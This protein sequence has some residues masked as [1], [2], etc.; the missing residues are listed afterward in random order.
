M[1]PAQQLGFDMIRQYAAMV[2][3]QPAARWPGVNLRELWA[4]RELF[5]FLVW[6]DMKVRYAQTVL[7]AGWAIVQPLATMV[8]FTI[9]FG[10]LA[11]LPSDGVPYAVFSLAALTPWNYFAGALVAASNSVLSHTDVITKIYFPRLIVPTAS[12]LGG[13]PNLAITLVILLI[14]LFAYGIT[15]APS[16]ILVIPLLL[17]IMMMTASGV[18]C[19][20]GAL[21]VQYR[22]VRNVAGVLVQLWMY[23]SPIVYPLSL[24]PDGYRALYML[25]PMVGVIEGFRSVLLG[26]VPLPY[27]AIAM[28]LVASL[29]LFTTGLICFRRMEQTFA[30]VA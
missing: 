26:T 6:R 15:P 2:D 8:V 7:G 4:Y 18:G 12:V 20:L 9:I 21:A 23:A 30:D 5:V 14:V 25:N 27:A 19:W 13:L 3:I 11:G 29:L 24:I 28:S 1:H 10:R 22:D 16:S 17:L